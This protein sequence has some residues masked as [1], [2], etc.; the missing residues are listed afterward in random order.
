M[1]LLNEAQEAKFQAISN[2]L[3]Q[4]RDQKSLSLE[5]V[6]MTTLVPMAALQA[7]DEGRAESLP[8][9]IYVQG[10]V[11]RYA[12]AVGLDGKEIAA[13]FAEACLPLPEPVQLS[14]VDRKTGISLS[15]ATPYIIFISL[16][17]AASFGLFYILNPQRGPESAVGNTSNSN[18]SSK[19][20][21]TTSQVASVPNPSAQVS[22][23]SSPSSSLQAVSSPSSPSPES[24]PTSTP[25]SSGA[26]TVKLDIKEESWIRVKVDGKIQFEGNLKAGESKDWS[27]NREITVESGNA[28]AVLIS[29]NN[30]PAE[31]MGQMYGVARKRYE[32]TLEATPTPTPTPTNVGN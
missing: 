23:V 22:P 27:G 8:E 21:E 17:A 32:A 7:I 20:K 12:D 19:Q 25:V 29:E 5:E 31:P 30:K 10:F 24:S 2:N 11:R 16:L 4:A 26:V 15:L 1:K 13:E 3:K 9:A 28:G 6:A 14:D 18:S